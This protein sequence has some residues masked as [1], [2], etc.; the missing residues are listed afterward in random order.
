[1]DQYFF[2]NDNLKASGKETQ[3]HC[4]YEVRYEING[5]TF[6]SPL[7][8]S[9]HFALFCP[10][11]FLHQLPIANGKGRPVTMDTSRKRLQA[12][13]CGWNTHLRLQWMAK[14]SVSLQYN[15]TNNERGRGP[16]DKSTVVSNSAFNVGVIVCIVNTKLAKWAMEVVRSKRPNIQTKTM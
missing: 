16:D 10:S 9:R 8:P 7:F 14:F 6:G 4:C 13:F 11:N 12:R 1:M 2:P 5:Q 15:C 3:D